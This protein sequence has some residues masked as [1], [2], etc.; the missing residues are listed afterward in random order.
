[1]RM[2]TRRW[3]RP[4]RE[5]ADRH[6]ETVMALAGVRSVVLFSADGFELASRSL[7]SE[8]SVRLAAIGSSLAALGTAISGEAGLRDFERT[9]IE[10]ADGT[11]V[12]MRIDGSDA[13][14]IAVVASRGTTLG[15]LLWATQHCCRELGKAINE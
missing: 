1:M 15:R 6:L 2:N 5:L 4:M 14:S 3:G 12:I 10:G 8:A 9:T 11:I 7:D 13:M